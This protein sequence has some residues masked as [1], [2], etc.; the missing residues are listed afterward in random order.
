MVRYDAVISNAIKVKTHTRYMEI[1]F[2]K[3]VLLDMVAILMISA[4]LAAL[5][6]LNIKVITS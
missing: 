4:K 3:H 5:R 6:I 1:A 2:N